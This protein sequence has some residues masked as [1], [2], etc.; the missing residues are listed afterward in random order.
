[1][2]DGDSPLTTL[3]ALQQ[4]LDKEIEAD[5]RTVV[6][7]IRRDPVESP[8]S[9]DA[10]E[11]ESKLLASLTE[12]TEAMLG[13]THLVAPQSNDRLLVLMRGDTA[14]AAAQRMERLRQDFEKTT[15]VAGEAE[16]QATITCGIAE[17]NEVASGAEL[18]ELADEAL[19]ESENDGTN[20]SYYHDGQFPSPVPPEEYQAKSQTIR[21]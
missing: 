2:F 1:M 12:M 11:V 16:L 10:T 9:V 4:E 21:I 13:E 15:F 19:L 5:S 17:A 6:A 18:L 3:S 7:T 14:D 20:R 8:D